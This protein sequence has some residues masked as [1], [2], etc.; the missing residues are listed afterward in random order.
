ME[1]GGLFYEQLGAHF[2]E[3]S[4]GQKTWEG[5]I[6]EMDLT[7]GNMTKRCTLDL[8]YN[9]VRTKYNDEDG[10]PQ[11]SDPVSNSVSIGRYGR[12]EEILLL[13]GYPQATAEGQRDSFLKENAWPWARVAGVNNRPADEPTLTIAVCGYIATANWRYASVTGGLDDVSDVITLIVDSDFELIQRGSIEENTFQVKKEQNIPQRAWDL[14]QFYLELGDPNTNIY[15]A[16]VDNERRFYYRAIDPA[17]VDYF[18]RGG[19]VYNSAG[20]SQEANY[21]QLKPGVYRAKD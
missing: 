15:R 21:W 11:E 3:R 16:Y 1:L 19:K 8:L 7:I 13:D 6:Y 18:Q 20:G 9:H 10:N 17:Q 14:I 4:G 2:E 12:R 5:L